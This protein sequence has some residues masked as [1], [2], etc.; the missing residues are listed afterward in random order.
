MNPGP[1]E[2]LH[3]DLRR[4]LLRPH[5]AVHA[6]RVQPA[7]RRL[8]HRRRREEHQRRGGGAEAVGPGSDHQAL[9]RLA[10]PPGRQQGESHTAR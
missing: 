5:G 4:A 6:G 2:R 3:G 7:L 1:D 8:R 10:L 9:Q